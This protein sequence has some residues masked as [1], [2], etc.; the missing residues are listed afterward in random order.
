MALAALLPRLGFT[1]R[2]APGRPRWPAPGSSLAFHALHGTFR[3]ACRPGIRPRSRA[4]STS[5]GTH[6][7]ASVAPQN[8][9]QV[10]TSKA[11]D[12]G[13]TLQSLRMPAFVTEDR[14]FSHRT[15]WLEHHGRPFP[16]ETD[17]A[18]RL[19]PDIFHCL[20]KHLRSHP[21]LFLFQHIEQMRLAAGAIWSRHSLAL[22]APV[23]RRL[24][25][26]QRWHHIS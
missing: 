2:N 1:A 18:W 17:Q 22:R 19:G 25:M 9:G 5:T 10:D 16:F 7:L 23:C 21:D 26:D 14:I 24:G 20:M 6:F 15:Y 4:R 12:A 11:A 3:D 13:L 8:S